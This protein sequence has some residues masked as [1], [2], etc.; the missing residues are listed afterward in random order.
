MEGRLRVL[1]LLQ[2]NNVASLS[3]SNSTLLL[4]GSNRIFL[5]KDFLKLLQCAAYSLYADEVPDNGLND[6]P[7][8]ENEH[9]VISD[10]LQG[11]GSTIGI[12]KADLHIDNI[13]Q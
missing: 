13:I 8:N 12:D 1:D 7:A 2:E 6:V 11:N 5:V 3:D 10:I 9:I 4:G